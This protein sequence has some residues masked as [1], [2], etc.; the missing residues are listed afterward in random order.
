MNS[1]DLL[2]EIDLCRKLVERVCFG[3]GVTIPDNLFS[4]FP[5]F[6]LDCLFSLPSLLICIR[7]EDIHTSSRKIGQRSSDVGTALQF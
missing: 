5:P 7:T 3:C 2:I 4:L 1:S 6:S